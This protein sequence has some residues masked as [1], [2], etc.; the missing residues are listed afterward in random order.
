MKTANEIP[1]LIVRQWLKDWD[2]VFFSKDQHRK[3]PDPN[4]YLFTLPAPY[5]RRLSDVYRR[6][7]DKPR[8][9]DMAIQRAHE[10]E[11]SDEIDLLH[12]CVIIGA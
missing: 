10:K 3:K 9:Q 1:A 7:A 12:K 6:K 4:F 5:L 8:S 11:R 2:D